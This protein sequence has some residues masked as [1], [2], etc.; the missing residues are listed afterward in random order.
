MKKFLISWIIGVSSAL[1]N[2]AVLA[3]SSTDYSLEGM[4][5]QTISLT[6]N[7]MTNIVFPVAIIPGIKVSR[8]ILVQKVKGVGNTIVLKALKKDFPP[9]NLSI[10]GVDGRLFSFELRYEDAPAL[11]NFRV[12]EH[13]ENVDPMLRD[14]EFIAGQKGFLH[15]SVTREKIQ[16]MLKGIYLQRNDVPEKASQGQV[17]WLSFI[18]K[19]HAAIDY[20][21]DYFRCSIRD[22]K[23]VK[24]GAVQE[25][26]I[27][28]AYKT[29]MGRLSG[30]SART[31]VVGFK[32]F[33]ISTG[34]ELILQL[35]EGNGRELQLRVSSAQLLKC[36]TL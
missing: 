14:A 23:R 7:K 18:L 35:G 24:R 1:M 27:M 20:T 28:P 33:T 9:T 36:K 10:Y 31:F 17:L 11:M 29:P 34:K 19:N 22:R 30:D 8:D 15:H 21:P 32:S 13:G 6:T 3:Q 16:L 2:G 12:I 5:A 4:G 26:P 25:I